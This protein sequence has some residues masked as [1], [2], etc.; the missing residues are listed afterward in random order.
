MADT[1]REGR[2]LIA[3][4]SHMQKV[5]HNFKPPFGLRPTAVLL[6]LKL[7]EMMEEADE[8]LP[9]IKMGDLSVML[10]QQMPAISRMV[11]E[12]SEQGL[13]SR[14]MGV[15]DRRIIY[16]GLTDAG[17]AMIGS[18]ERYVKD[19]ARR[20]EDRLGEKDSRE[21]RRLMDRLADILDETE[22]QGGD[23]Q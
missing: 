17:W 15:C 2:E 23:A 4:F 8:T 12:L 9:G 18:I 19:V 14:R 21:F 20:V 5:V 1:V 13:V 22:T 3:A 16:V 7:G 11:K 10:H 6:L